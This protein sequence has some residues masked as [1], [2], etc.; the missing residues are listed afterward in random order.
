MEVLRKILL[1]VDAV[2]LA[3]WVIT[4]AK[5]FLIIAFTAALAALTAKAIEKMK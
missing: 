2:C 5:M 3:A 1:A 4:Q